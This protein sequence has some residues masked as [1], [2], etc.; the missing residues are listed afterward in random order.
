MNRSLPLL[1]LL[2]VAPAASA[3]SCLFVPF[4]EQLREASTVFVATVTSA[5][6]EEPFASFKNGTDYRVN[7]R[8]LV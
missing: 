8:Y 1:T 3:T 5:S 2:L 4:E 7:Y 6:S